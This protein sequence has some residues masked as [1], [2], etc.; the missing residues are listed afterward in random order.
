MRHCD[1]YRMPAESGRRGRLAM[2][3]GYRSTPTA[4]AGR[5][6]KVTCAFRVLHPAGSMYDKAEQEAH[7]PLRKNKESQRG[8]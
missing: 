3:N 2:F 5:M 7:R 8:F 6:L 4:C 1:E